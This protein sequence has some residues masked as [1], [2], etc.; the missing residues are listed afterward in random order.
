LTRHSL[1]LA[2]NGYQKTSIAHYH[3]DDLERFVAVVRDGVAL[4][5]PRQHGIPGGNARFGFAFVKNAGTL[6]DDVDLILGARTT[7]TWP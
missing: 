7:C 1:S 4:A 2:Q 5:I 6:Q 3:R